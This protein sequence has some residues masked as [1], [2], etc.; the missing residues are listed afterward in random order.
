M[1]GQ[2]NLHHTLGIRPDCEYMVGLVI[3][4]LYV[5]VK[6]VFMFKFIKTLHKG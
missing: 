3:T 5:D 6:F 2:E 4:K 1:F